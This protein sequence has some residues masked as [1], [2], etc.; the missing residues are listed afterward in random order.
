M[1]DTIL[2]TGGAGFIGSTLVRAALKRGDTV[3]VIDDLSTGRRDNLDGLDAELIEASILDG[4]AL[5][6]A[7]DGC[8][9]VFHMAGQVSVPRSIE[10]PT[11]THEVNATGSMRVYEAARTAGVQRVVYSASCA[12]YGQ[13]EVL[14]ITETTTLAPESPY[15]ASKLMGELYGAAWTESM[16]LEVVSLRYFNVYGPRQNPE[17][18]YAAA[19]PAFIT[20][21]L[22]GEDITIFGDGEQTRDFVFVD[23]V[24]KANLLAAEA[25]GAAGRVANIGSGKR[26]SVNKLVQTLQTI[27]PSASAVVHGPPRSGEVRHS[28]ADVAA[29]DR[30]FDFNA[31]VSLPEGLARTVAWYQETAS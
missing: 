30:L 20:R 25:P 22:G 19:I 7:I 11:L 4:D 17:G 2:V 8:R 13:A 29:A 10:A 14:P 18:G 28:V 21:L 9:A 31:T 6:R 1:T 23:D 3:R 5:A 15:A 12:A 26:I 24:V 16:G 27:I